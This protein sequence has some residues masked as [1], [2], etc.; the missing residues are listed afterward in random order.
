MRRIFYEPKAH[1][2]NNINNT[3][4]SALLIKHSLRN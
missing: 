3:P 4:L 1:K 2:I